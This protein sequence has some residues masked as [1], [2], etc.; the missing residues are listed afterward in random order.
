MRTNKFR[1]A[2]IGLLLQSS[3]L[4]LA[5]SDGSAVAASKGSPWYAP[6]QVSLAIQAEGGASVVNYE[7]SSSHD[8]KIT[9]DAEGRTS[10]IMLVNGR[11]Q[12]M[13]AKNALLEK[14]YE[15]DALD[16]P[17]LTLN[18]VLELLR[19]AV[20][21]GPGGISKSTT[22]NLDEKTKPIVVNT[23]SASGGVEA[24]WSLRGTIEPA[25]TGQWSFDLTVTHDQPM[26]VTGRWRKEA[27]GPIFAD[28]M[29]LAGWQILS[30][31]PMRTM[32]G[33]AT[34]V[35]YGAQ[36]VQQQPQTLGELRRLAVTKD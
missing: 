5:Q 8:L 23:A 27:A 10:E 4:L 20:P 13:L 14:G 34:I 30:L 36:P 2:L 9:T 21:S 24:P 25:A 11:S 32:D 3:Y 31:G 35:D 22:F 33:D 7:I 18:L 15:I 29:P 12:W 28:D 17:V 16:G 6:T 26:H 1:L 19:A